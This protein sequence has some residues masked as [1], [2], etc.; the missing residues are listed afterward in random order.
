MSGAQGGAARSIK[1]F[2]RDCAS[3]AA[4]VRRRVEAGT[5]RPADV[6]SLMHNLRRAPEQRGFLGVDQSMLQ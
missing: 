2:I 6:L 4:Q 5:H 1:Q 3:A